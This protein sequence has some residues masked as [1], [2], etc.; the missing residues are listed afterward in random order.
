MLRDRTVSTAP[1]TLGLQLALAVAGTVL[2]AASAKVAV[3]M[4][5]VPITLQTL[6]LPLLVL[7]LGRNLAVTST[8]MYLAAGASGLP[9]FAPVGGWLT[10]G[11]LVMYPIAAFAM[12]TLLDRGLAASWLGRWT[13]IFAGDV[14]VFAGGATWLMVFAHLSVAQTIALGVTPFIIGDLLKITIASALPSQAAK[15]AARFNL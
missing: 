2:L 3:P 14:I 5:P 13:A 1:R 8:L 10:M 7:A 11:Y 12:G 6:A 15:I 9:V 4:V